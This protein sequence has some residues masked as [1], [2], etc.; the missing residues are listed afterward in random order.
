MGKK[1]SRA[2]LKLNKERNF[3]TG[4]KSIWSWYPHSSVLESGFSPFKS[5][6]QSLWF[7]GICNFS[8]MVFGGEQCSFRE[9]C[10]KDCRNFKQF[11]SSSNQ[12]IGIM[13]SPWHVPYAEKHK[14]FVFINE[15]EWI[16]SS[17]WSFIDCFLTR[18]HRSIRDYE[19]PFWS[20]IIWTN[21]KFNS[22]IPTVH[23]HLSRN[24]YY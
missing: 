23:V 12:R 15:H 3:V 6:K 20:N 4:L 21:E 16:P 10:S 13:I 9:K 24:S 7:S 8:W 19:F 5:S 17:I 1:S 22:N 18:G 14:D 11:L 2:I